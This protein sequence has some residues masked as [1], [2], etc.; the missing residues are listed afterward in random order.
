M[1]QTACLAEPAASSGLEAALAA[2]ALPSAHSHSEALD[3]TQMLA[4]M[5]TLGIADRAKTIP[6]L[7]KGYGAALAAATGLDDASVKIFTAPE[8]AEEYEITHSTDGKTRV[9]IVSQA[10]GDF[11]ASVMLES[12]DQRA[13]EMMSSS[14][15]LFR[16][17]EDR[18]VSKI[19]DKMRYWKD[20][21]SGLLT[22]A[23]V[24]ECGIERR[25]DAENA[26]EKGFGIIYMDI[27]NFKTYNDIDESHQMGDS[28]IRMAGDAIRKST[29]ST[30]IPVREGQSADEFMVYVFGCSPEELTAV[31][32]RIRNALGGYEIPGHPDLNITASIGV[33]H[34]YEATGTVGTSA[35]MGAIKSL[36]DRRMY[37]AK[38]SGRDRV[39][40]PSL[41][42]HTSPI[43]AEG[44]YLPPDGYLAAAALPMPGAAKP[45]KRVA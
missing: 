2:Q 24:D 12:S 36:A 16:M 19:G 14:N 20:R 25:I 45:G 8:Q 38:S 44:G 15:P 17:F 4:F 40:G 41:K 28:V 18:V 27:D 23:Y 22:D 34:S 9:G 43:P 31:A 33:A 37:E 11:Y 1:A 5:E 29:R 30:D 13:M 21:R 35:K 3:A 32:E 39:I 6:E 26:K 42:S 7:E 10:N